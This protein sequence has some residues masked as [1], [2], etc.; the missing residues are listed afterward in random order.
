M[1]DCHRKIILDNVD[2]LINDTDYTK[3]VNAC[4]QSGLIS[5]IMKKIIEVSTKTE[6]SVY[7]I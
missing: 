3:L 4:E 1:N 2:Y 5:S 7:G 6:Y